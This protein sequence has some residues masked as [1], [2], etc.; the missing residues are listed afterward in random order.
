MKR[1]TVLLQ[2]WLVVFTAVLI[3]C[4]SGSRVIDVEPPPPLTDEEARTILA[5]IAKTGVVGE[6]AMQLS[7]QLAAETGPD[8]ENQ[9]KISG[10]LQEMIVYDDPDKNKKLAKAALEMW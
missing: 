6:E 8:R 1:A 7:Y 2:M 9:R 4:G 5:D 3:G 10:L